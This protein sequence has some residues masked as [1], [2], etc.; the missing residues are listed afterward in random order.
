M[1]FRD[2]DQI[3][4]AAAIGRNAAFNVSLRESAVTDKTDM[5]LN[6][7]R[8]TQSGRGMIDTASSEGWERE[9]PSIRIVVACIAHFAIKIRNNIFERRNG[10]LDG[11]DLL[12]LIIS[13]RTDAVLQRDHQLTP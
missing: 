4:L 6:V 10:L 12:E 3:D 9:H 11:R 8:E 1:S 13:D 5:S 2:R 7:H